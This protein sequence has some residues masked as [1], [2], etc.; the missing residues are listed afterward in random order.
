MAGVISFTVPTAAWMLSPLILTL[1]VDGR[2]LAT[3][4][5]MLTC[6]HPWF[7]TPRVEGCPFAPVQA[8]PA[9]VQRFEHGA[10]I[11]LAAMDSIY[12]LYDAPRFGDSA[13]LERYDDAFVEGSPEPPLP[14][15]PPSGRFAPVRGFGLVWRTMTRVRSDLGWALEPE[16][17][18][19]ACLGYAHYGGKSM[20][21]YVS[22][23]DR[24][25]LEFEIYY[26][27]VRWRALHEIGGRPVTVVGC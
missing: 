10:M 5:L 26:V 25:L 16:Q 20:R 14:A 1:D 22:T 24:G 15:E 18:Y 13:L 6:D 12:V 21:A 23:I 7:F 8:T 2:Q 17:G 27:P 11:W 3:Q 4:R 9:A 19:T